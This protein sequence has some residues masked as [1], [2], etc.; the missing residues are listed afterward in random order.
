MIGYGSDRASVMVGKH[1]S[2]LSR[3]R[4]KSPKVYDMGCIC[5]VINTC[6]SY[7]LKKLPSSVD[8]LLVDVFY[9][10]EHRY[11]EVKKTIKTQ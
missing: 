5:H 8:E 4:E 2:V 3:V 9:H 1:N 7:G 11:C 10:F 6:L